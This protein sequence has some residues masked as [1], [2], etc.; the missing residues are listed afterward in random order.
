M[1]IKENG[2]YQS[3]YG[4]PITELLGSSYQSFTTESSVMVVVIVAVMSITSLNVLLIIKHRRQKIIF[5]EENGPQCGPFFIY[6]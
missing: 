1:D 3:N 4:E 6:H 5:I 2:A